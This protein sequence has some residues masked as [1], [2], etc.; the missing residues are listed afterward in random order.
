MPKYTSRNVSNTLFYAFIAFGSISQKS[1]LIHW[2][3]LRLGGP[4]RKYHAFKQPLDRIEF[5]F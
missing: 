1:F 2:T 4:N 3:C 5:E